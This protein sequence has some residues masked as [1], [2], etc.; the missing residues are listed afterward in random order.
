VNSYSWLLTS[1]LQIFHTCWGV[2]LN[3]HHSKNYSIMINNM[4][5]TQNKQHFILNVASSFM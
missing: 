5:K 3:D 4:K 2:Q 1:F